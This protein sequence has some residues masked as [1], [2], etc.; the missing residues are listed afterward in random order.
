M[1]HVIGDDM[2][3][4]SDNDL[5]PGQ[6]SSLGKIIMFAIGVGSLVYSAARVSVSLDS[7]KEQTT[8]L[9]RTQVEM[10]NIITT[11]QINQATINEQMATI[12]AMIRK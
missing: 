4:K 6:F 7:L 12:R 1:T 2:P 10:G 5:S 8:S 11:I 3:N 9:Q